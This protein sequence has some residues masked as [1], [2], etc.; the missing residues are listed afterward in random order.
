MSSTELFQRAATL[1]IGAIEITA[2][3]FAFAVSA[4]VKPQ[5]NKA[6]IRVWNMNPDHR[7]Q[8]EGAG[9]LP[10]RLDAGY[11]GGT[12]TIFL[13][14]LRTCPTTREGPDLITTVESGDGERAIRTSRVKV[15]AAKGTTVDQILRDVA[16]AIGVAPGNLA[17][18]TKKLKAAG[19]GIFPA[20][21]VLTG[22]AAREM[23]HLCKGLGLEWSVQKGALQILE[24]GK[25]VAGE[26][27]LMSKKTGMIDAPTVDNK[28]V[29]SVSSLLN[30]EIFPGRLLVLEGDRLKGQYRIEECA[31]QGDTHGS[32]WRVDMKAARY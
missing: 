23:T 31:F 1:T 6:T 10:V 13:G 2:L 27:I 9:V 8:I 19:L 12:Q 22:S 5:P 15:S 11:I 7:S 30:P 3:R 29:L 21:T 17:D 25:A 26:A 18:A 14:D 28:G 16:S 24:R 20:G 32:E 4:S